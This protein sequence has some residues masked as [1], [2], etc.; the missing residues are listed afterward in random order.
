MLAL[1]E[2][3]ANKSSRYYELIPASGYRTEA[4]PPIDNKM[5][6]SRKFG[7]IESLIDIEASTKILLGIEKIFFH[8]I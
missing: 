1:K 3:I 6:L 8:S 5:L 7:E 2:D 4:I